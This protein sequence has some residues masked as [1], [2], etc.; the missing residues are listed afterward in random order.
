[1][2]PYDGRVV[3][4]FILQALVGEDITIYGDGSQTR[5]FC[6]VDDLLDGFELMMNLEPAEGEAPFVGPVNLGNPSEFTIKQLAQMCIEFTNSRSKLIHLPLPA[7]DPT[8]RK[9]D[10]ALAQQKLGWEPKVSLEEGLRKTIEYFASLDLGRFRRP[11]K[12]SLHRSGRNMLILLGLRLLLRG[13]LFL[14]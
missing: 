1:M 11:T 12:H 8:Q 13:G 6:Y 4:N 7:D 5:S 9:P 10:I 3:S 2:H 14:I